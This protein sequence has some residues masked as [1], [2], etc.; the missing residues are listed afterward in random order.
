MSYLDS[1]VKVFVHSQCKTRPIL[2][3]LKHSTVHL[4]TH[5][6]TSILY[7]FFISCPQYSQHSGTHADTT[8][9]C[10]IAYYRHTLWFTARQKSRDHIQILK[11]HSS[12]QKYNYSLT[13]TTQFTHVDWKKHKDTS[14]LPLLSW[15]GKVATPSLKKQL[16]VATGYDWVLVYCQCFSTATQC[17]SLRRDLQ[18]WD[19]QKEINVSVTRTQNFHK[20]C[21]V[22]YKHFSSS[23]WAKDF[24]HCT[25][26][27]R[28]LPMPNNK[29]KNDRLQW[30]TMIPFQL[31]ASLRPQTVIPQVQ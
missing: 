22:C 24:H 8:V 13:F 25:N 29:S 5:S 18:S 19:S 4:K 16:L 15:Q 21:S 26:M 27:S 9:E 23:P 17:W 11:T 1:S 10:C 2:S 3:F 14:S 31:W 7:T 20:D 6:H 30:N 12:S 28:I